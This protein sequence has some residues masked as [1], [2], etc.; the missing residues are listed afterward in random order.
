MKKVIIDG[1]EYVPAHT[2][3]VKSEAKDEISDLQDKLYHATRGKANSEYVLNHELSEANATIQSLNDE[4]KKFR[5]AL[6]DAWNKLDCCIVGC[7][8]KTKFVNAEFCS[9]HSSIMKA[10]TQKAEE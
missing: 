7:R 1:V 5:D 9:A 3:E 4:N 6:K 10:L 8:H 2:P